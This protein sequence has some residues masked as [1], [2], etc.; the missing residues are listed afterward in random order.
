M[1]DGIS[2]S[3]YSPVASMGRRRHAVAQQVDAMLGRLRAGRWHVL[4]F[5]PAV[6]SMY[7]AD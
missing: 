4:R 2:L 1:V 6:N 5:R 3:G 7:D